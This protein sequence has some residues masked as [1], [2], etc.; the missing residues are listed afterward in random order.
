MKIRIHLLA[1]MMLIFSSMAVS[2]QAAEKNT[3]R[4]Q[5][6]VRALEIKNRVEQIQALDISTLN[7]EQRSEIKNELKGMHKELKQMGPITI[8]LSLGALIVIILLLILIF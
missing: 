7:K 6:E 5:Q 1:L 2:T 8:V 3:V 4:A